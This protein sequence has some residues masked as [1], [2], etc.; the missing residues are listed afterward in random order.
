MSTQILC[1]FP[2][3]RASRVHARRRLRPK[4]PGLWIT[5]GGQR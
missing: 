1:T 4:P 5:S 2:Q 3:P